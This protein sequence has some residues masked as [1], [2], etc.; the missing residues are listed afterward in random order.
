MTNDFHLS[1]F[2]ITVPTPEMEE[3]ADVL[4]RLQSAGTCSQMAMQADFCEILLHQIFQQGAEIVARS[5]QAV[6]MRLE[7]PSWRQC[8]FDQ[9]SIPILET[10]PDVESHE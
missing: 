8:R 6:Q 9:T 1:L 4:V 7:A 10:S 5:S 3:E 2:R